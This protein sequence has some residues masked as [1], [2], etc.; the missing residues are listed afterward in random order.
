MQCGLLKGERDICSSS[1]RNRFA[2]PR[3]IFFPHPSAPLSQLSSNHRPQQSHNHQPSHEHFQPPP[4]AFF[5]Q[6]AEGRQSLFAV[7]QPQVASRIAVRAFETRKRPPQPPSGRVFPQHV[8]VYDLIQK[9]IL[10]GQ[11]N[12]VETPLCRNLLIFNL[13]LEQILQK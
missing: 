10:L 8:E 5:F 13:D 6:F 7:H 4:V 12:S 1:L 11:G 3:E 9:L 2:R